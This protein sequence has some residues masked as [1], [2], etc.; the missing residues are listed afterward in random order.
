M[1]YTEVPMSTQLE[2]RI[3]RS[4]D[5]QVALAFQLA[6]SQERA[7]FSSIALSDELGTVIAAAGDKQVCE[8]MAALS[9]I[10]VDDQDLWKGS[11]KTE[12]GDVRAYVKPVVVSGCTLYLSAAEGKRLAVNRELSTSGE[13]VARILA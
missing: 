13:G 3:N 4:D 11:V 2:R 12:T 9:P 8:H 7:R 5:V 6:A 10:V 1:N